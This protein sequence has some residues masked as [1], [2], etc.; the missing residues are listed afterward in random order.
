M[1]RLTTKAV[2]GAVMALLILSGGL[3]WLRRQR[4]SPAQT[5]QRPTQPSR[6]D[7]PKTGRPKT[8]RPIKAKP[9][10]IVLQ[11]VSVWNTNQRSQ[12]SSVGSYQHPPTPNLP[13][14]A[15]QAVPTTPAH[16]LLARLTQ[17]TSNV[18]SLSGA[19]AAEINDLLAKLAASGTA[20]IPAIRQFLQDGQDFSFA[21]IAGGNLVNYGTMRLGLIDA[22]QQIGGPEAVEL[23]AATLQTTAE[24]FEIAFLSRYLEQ[25]APGKFRDLELTAARESLALASG[26]IPMSDVSA[27]FEL[28][29]AYGDEN[30][31]PSLEKAVS[32]WNYYATLALAGLPNGAGIPT[33]IKLAQD[34]AVSAMGTGD[35]AL[36]PL[37]QAAPQYPEAARALLEAARQNQIPETAW[38]TVAGALAGTYIQYG[39]Q[40]NGSTAPTLT[41]SPE[42]MS[43]RIALINQLLTVTSSPAGQQALQNA[44]AS[45]S[46]RLPK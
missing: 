37:A 43:Q 11:E 44:L 38:S 4:P 32:R 23:A 2:L 28:L 17:L 18:N 34:P 16:Q 25:Q 20:A 10:T 45:V 5:N 13:V 21:S 14:Q 7:A 9:G 29:Q 42:Q 27:L 40:I 31:V 46:G 1:T 36:R 12:V 19:Q 39:N 15:A 3:L 24:P 33:L 35:F 6:I 41:W 30:V 26:R 22:L 8:G